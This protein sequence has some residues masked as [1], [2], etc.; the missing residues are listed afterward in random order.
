MNKKQLG[1]HIERLLNL[2]KKTMDYVMIKHN[3]IGF[4]NPYI[5]GEKITY[6]VGV[7]KLDF[8]VDNISE[9]QFTELVEL[10]LF[11]FYFVRYILSYIDQS[12]ID[13]DRSKFGL[14]IKINRRILAYYAGLLELNKKG[15]TKWT[16]LIY[17]KKKQ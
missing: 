13:F 15:E 10:F 2:R 8:D 16:Y 9:K 11:D 17:L 14:S 5:L 12:G 6:S 3:E 7:S 4:E 1:R